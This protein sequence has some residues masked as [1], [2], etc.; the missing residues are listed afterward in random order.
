MKPYKY[1]YPLKIQ[2]EEL[3]NKKYSD[4]A[5]LERL[6]RLIDLLEVKI[7]I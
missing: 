4:S 5:K 3:S 2:L 6:D 7:I 1:S